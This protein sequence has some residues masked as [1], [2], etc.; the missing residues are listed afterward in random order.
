MLN[1]RSDWGENEFG[2]REE[3]EDDITENYNPYAYKST[4]MTGLNSPQEPHLMSRKQLE[5]EG[6]DLK[7]YIQSISPDLNEEMKK[8]VEEFLVQK[9]KKNHQF[10]LTLRKLQVRHPLF[11][12]INML[13][14]KWLT[15][16]CMILKFSRGQH[17]YK[18]DQLCPSR[19]YIVLYGRFQ[20][21]YKEMNSIDGDFGE[22]CGLGYTL[23]EEAIQNTT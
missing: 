22:K 16:R 18:Q 21:H 9:Q 12:L 5:F 1:D 3:N 23:G 13:T 2:I 10:H 8:V 7:S 20:Y 19:A 14:F 6:L 15:D 4:S 17:L 11:R